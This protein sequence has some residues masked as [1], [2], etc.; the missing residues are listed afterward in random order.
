MFIH[1]PETF[2]FPQHI[3]M[4]L[5]HF[6]VPGAL[7]CPFS[8]MTVY[9]F[10]NK[11]NSIMIIADYSRHILLRVILQVHIYTYVLFS[12]SSHSSS[13]YCIDVSTTTVSNKI[14]SIFLGNQLSY[15]L[16]IH[17]CY[18][19]LQITKMRQCGLNNWLLKHKQGTIETRYVYSHLY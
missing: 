11:S 8:F 12:V 9:Y 3:L 4:S 10:R 16:S 19:L 5:R 13:K 2:W 18:S 15:R 17:T 1:I 14:M 6:Y 7:L